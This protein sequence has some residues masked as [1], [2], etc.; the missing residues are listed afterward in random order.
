MGIRR[1]D[2][3]SK[4]QAIELEAFQLIPTRSL[5]DFAR[6]KK[7]RYSLANIQVDKIIG[8]EVDFKRLLLMQEIDWGYVKLINPKLDIYADAR[9]ARRPRP[10]KAP[11]TEEPSSPLLSTLSTKGQLQRNRNLTDTSGLRQTLRDIPV[12]IKVD[13]FQVKNAR[14]T[15][16]QQNNSTMG[17][18]LAT[19]LV[20]N[21]HCIVPQIRLGKATKDPG[22]EHFYSGNILFT[23]K[24][25]Q[26]RDAKD[27][28]TCTL[29]DIQ[30]SLK[31]SLLQIQSISYKPLKSQE[32]FNANREHQG[33]YVDLELSSIQSNAIDL[34]RLIFDQLLIKSWPRS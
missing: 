23:L 31:D 9:K 21:I 24:N 5:E 7:H 12:Y 27:E 10:K 22:F 13:T 8:G 18:G 29:K 20:D 28:F 30:S 6:R 16:R 4:T 25:Y 1:I 2:I 26:F 19:H 33:L 32:K 3:S 34:D 14:I 15:Y 11:K 17:K